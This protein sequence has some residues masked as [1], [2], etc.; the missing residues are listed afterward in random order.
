VDY[1]RDTRFD[2][3]FLFKYSSRPGTRAAGLPETVSE[4]EKSRRLAAL[5]DLQHGISAEA[6]RRW[7]GREVE[8]LVEGPARRDP[9]RLYARTRQLK[10]VIFPDDGTPAGALR[11]LRVVGATAMTLQGEPT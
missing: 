4:E 8:G 1:L 6:N 7:V 9:T 11:T 5:I 10:A 2:G 3:A